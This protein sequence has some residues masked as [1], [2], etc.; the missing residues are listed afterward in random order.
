MKNYFNQKGLTLVELLAALALVGIIATIAGSVVTQ[1]FQSNSIVQ[2]EIDLKQ[3]TNSILTI[4]REE[5]T[6]QNMKICLVD[7]HTLTMDDDNQE[8]LLY[9]NLLT[10]ENMTISELYIEN[11]NNSSSSPSELDINSSSN[12]SGDNCITTAENPIYI[13]LATAANRAGEQDQT[14][15]TSTVI[16]NRSENVNVEIPDDSNED[17]ETDP[18]QPDNPDIFTL[19]SEFLSIL[20]NR[21]DDG[22]FILDHPNGDKNK[23]EFDENIKLNKKEDIAPYGTKCK[24][25]NYNK[26]L[27]S[28][29]SMFINPTGWDFAEVN[30]KGNLYQENKVQFGN[31]SHLN[32]SGNSHISNNVNLYGNGKMSLHN[33]YF[34]NKVSLSNSASISSTGSVRSDGIVELSNNNQLSVIGYGFFNNDFSMYNNSL[35][36]AEKLFFGENFEMTKSN[37]TSST[38]LNFLGV[39]SFYNNS[40]LSAGNDMIFEKK[41][42]GGNS[43]LQSEGNIKL[44][45]GGELYQNT[46]T[47]KGSIIF[48][49]DLKMGN[50]EINSEKNISFEEI[51]E[52]N[53]NNLFSKGNL[54][55]Y[56]NAQIGGSSLLSENSTVFQKEAGFNNSELQ[57]N[58]NIQFNDIV[59]L[60]NSEIYSEG[61]ITFSKEMNMGNSSSISSKGNIIFEEAAGYSW[62]RGSICTEGSI[63]GREHI[64]GKF[65][66]QEGGSCS[67]P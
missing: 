62:S 49:K 2:D 63:V 10:K 5:V 37:L 25:T 54:N 22:E 27:W 50:S 3:Q 56:D 26:S 47:S 58:G 11:L 12:L 9:D 41:T 8:P 28:H 21:F 44:N 24:V 40:S 57:S 46:L 30:V 1:T 4:I 66:I 39:S 34:K 13:K 20:D 32:V 59:E 18:P 35:L 61:N 33:T 16:N 7:R 17:D 38:D 19:Q 15:K 23:C 67:K 64:I 52:F 36:E 14:Y 48:M 51:K 45:G 6:Q 60:G 43:T 31:S 42:Y 29:Y 55:F 65:N 53:Q